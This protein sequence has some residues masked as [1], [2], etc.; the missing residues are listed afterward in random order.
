MGL[1]CGLVGFF[2]FFLAWRALMNSTSLM[3]LDLVV[4]AVPLAVPLVRIVSILSPVFVARPGT[5]EQVRTSE[6]AVLLI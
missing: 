3:G 5:E 2:G 1:A 4:S 6:P